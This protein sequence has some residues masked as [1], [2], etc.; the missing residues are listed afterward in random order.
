MLVSVTRQIHFTVL[1]KKVGAFSLDLFYD[2][3]LAY[4]M[5][6]YGIHWEYSLNMLAVV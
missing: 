3:T 5:N 4:V 6:D 2:D 1:M